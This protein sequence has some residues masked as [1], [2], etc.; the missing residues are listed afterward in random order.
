MSCHCPHGWF[1]ITF[2]ARARTWEGYGSTEGEGVANR[3]EEGN[4]KG[5]SS[6]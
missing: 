2:A 4:A 1:A 3:D 6:G 5:E